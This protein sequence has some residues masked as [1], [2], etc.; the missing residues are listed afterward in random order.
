MATTD[1]DMA[2]TFQDS[3]PHTFNS[4]QKLVM[5]MAKLKKNR[6]RKTFFGRDKGLESLNHFED[7]L[8]DSLQSMILDRA[9]SPLASAEEIREILVEMIIAFAQVFPNWQDAYSFAEEYFVRDSK[10]AEARIAQMRGQR[11][12]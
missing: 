9:I 5:A 10:E 12:V 1:W 3:F 8:R 11:D 6:G 4:L 2:G 7:T